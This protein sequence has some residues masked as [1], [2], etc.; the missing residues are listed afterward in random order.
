MFVS[1]VRNLLLVAGSSTMQIDS[2]ISR[3]RD[4]FRAVVD[5]AIKLRA[6]IGEDV[7]SCDFETIL[8]HPGDAFDAASMVDAFEGANAAGVNS[9]NVLCTSGLGLRRCKKVK[10]DGDANAQWEVTVLQKPQVVL[11]SAI[12]Q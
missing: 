4:N 7:I 10:M 8:I 3:T 1:D 9:K 6:A 5:A 12:S 2:L 11:Q